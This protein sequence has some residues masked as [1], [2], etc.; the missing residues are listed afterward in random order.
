MNI[1]QNKKILNFYMQNAFNEDSY[2]TS[3]MPKC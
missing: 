1:K 3:K 2:I